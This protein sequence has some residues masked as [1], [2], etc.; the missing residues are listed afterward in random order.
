MQKAIGWFKGND[1][2]SEMIGVGCMVGICRIVFVIITIII[3]IV[4]LV[5]VL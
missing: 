3:L 2:Q 1:Y 4:V 5:K